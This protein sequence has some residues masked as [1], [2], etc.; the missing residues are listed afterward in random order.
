MLEGNEEC[1]KTISTFLNFNSHS[2]WHFLASFSLFL[3]PDLPRHSTYA[4]RCL[5][6]LSTSA[7]S[8]ISSLP[9]GPLRRRSEPEA[10]KYPSL[11][12]IETLGKYLT[13]NLTGTELKEEE[14]YAQVQIWVNIGARTFFF[15]KSIPANP[16]KER[17]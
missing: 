14:K 7:V 8:F 1:L 11:F 15:F 17:I 5:P 2:S 3:S 9:H 12:C 10:A 13:R 4:H 6:P 16:G